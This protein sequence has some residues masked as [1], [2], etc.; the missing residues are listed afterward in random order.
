MQV[1]KSKDMFFKKYLASAFFIYVVPQNSI[2]FFMQNMNQEYPCADLECIHIMRGSRKFC[3]KGSNSD[4]VHY[5]HSYFLVDEGIGSKY[6]LKRAIIGSP[7][8][9]H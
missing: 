4:N 7:A 2:N 1:H 6:H 3:Q 9:R 8:K 5:Y